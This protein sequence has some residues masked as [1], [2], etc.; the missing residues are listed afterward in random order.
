MKLLSFC[1]LSLMAIG[2]LFA[3]DF[4]GEPRTALVMGAWKY[5][6]GP[7][8]PLP[9]IANDVLKMAEKLESLGFDVV[10]VENPNLVEAERAINDFGAKLK[11]RKGV[12]LF[13]FSGHG[14]ELQGSNFLIPTGIKEL[15]DKS[16]LK[17]KALNAQLVLNRMS[18]AQARINLIFLDCC[19]NELTKAITDTGLAPM[20][21]RGV[22][23]GF[24]TASGASAAAGHDG[25]PYTIALLRH[26]D[27]E[28][29]EIKAMHTL[30][31]R[32]VV[33]ESRGAGDEQS[34][35]ESASL[36]GNFYFRPGKASGLSDNEI[37][38]QVEAALREVN[39][40]RLT[41][42]QVRA[43]MKEEIDKVQRVGVQG[44]NS[45]PD[46]SPPPPPSTRPD[47]WLFSDS[48][49]RYLSDRELSSLSKD[50]LWR[51]R[52]EIYARRGFIFT[53][54]RGRNF[55]GAL[56]GNYRGITSNMEA[57]EQAFNIYERVN[58]E[59]IKVHER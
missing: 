59:R 10:R 2:S 56:G 51:A 34:P 7:F 43:I 46:V 29:L 26:M 32:D 37:Q 41:A 39:T 53:S 24:A 1:F 57:V 33:L 30:V 11:E 54:A 18:A 3:E 55:T 8:Q 22:F 12:G 40:G 28:G 38:K 47:P 48:S 50:E 36:T 25:S 49:S 45:K 35:F 13:Y 23:I 42:E 14:A 44:Q 58:V 20:S 15:A 17:V 19:R 4:T 27:K 21:S 16:D 9:G 6:G 5:E 52:N 31:T